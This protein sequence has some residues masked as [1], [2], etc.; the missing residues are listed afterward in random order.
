MLGAGVCIFPGAGGGKGGKPAERDDRSIRPKFDGEKIKL[1]NL[2]EVW[3]GEKFIP[4]QFSKDGN[5]L[6]ITTPHFSGLLLLRFDR[7]SI[8]KLCDDPGA[9]IMPRFLPESN[10]VSYITSRGESQFAYNISYRGIRT[11][12]EPAQFFPELADGSKVTLRRGKLFLV[13][14]GGYREIS[15]YDKRVIHFDISSDKKLLFFTADDYIIY[16]YSV[17]GDNVVPVVRGRRGV[18]SPNGNYFIYEYPE[19]DGERLVSSELYLYDIRNDLNYPLTSTRDV[20]E[21][22]PVISPDGM[23]L[24]FSDDGK[25]YLAD[26]IAKIK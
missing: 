22:Y 13:K 21:E 4:R 1:V 8:R 18:V 5:E 25:I 3:V 12:I 6:L 16:Q 23:K 14:E 9:G 2:R 15:G 20:N 7:N 17:E 26:V 24:A 10:T 19:I 11:E